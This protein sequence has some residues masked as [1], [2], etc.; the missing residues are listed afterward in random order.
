MSISQIY[1]DGQEPGAHPR[2]RERGGEGHG[3]EAHTRQAEQEGK[4]AAA[5]AA[6][7]GAG[8]VDRCLNGRRKQSDK[9]P[10]AAK[11][12]TFKA[13]KPAA[14]FCPKCGSRM[15]DHKDR[16]ACGI[17][18]VHRV[19]GEGRRR[20]K[21]DGPREEETRSVWASR[22]SAHL[23]SYAFLAVWRQGSSS[24][25]PFS[26]TPPTSAA[27]SSHFAADAAVELAFPAAALLLAFHGARA[28]A[29][30]GE[31]LGLGQGGLTWRNVA[32]G[33]TDLHDTLRSSSSSSVISQV[34]GITISTNVD[35]IFVAAPLWFLCRSPRWS[36][37]MMRGGPLQGADGAQAR[38]NRERADLRRAALRATTPPSGS[39]SSRRRLR[40][41]R[42]I[43][44]QEDG[45]ALPVD[46]CACVRQHAD[47]VLTPCSGLRIDEG[48]GHYTS[49]RSTR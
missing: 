27:A 25:P 43:R 22:C 6:R 41:H 20:R 47:T 12:K 13:Y 18:Q 4:A 33:S 16:Y 31:R 44:L 36:S 2:V 24:S 39:R 1:G 3:A 45:L 40:A 21:G 26:T 37:P 46:D 15:G 23:S 35:Q 29:E 7:G 11:K 49:S 9:K 5:A 28:A 8:E 19:E 14:K 32:L 34:A 38:D 48:K 42:G 30:A 10:A 17:V